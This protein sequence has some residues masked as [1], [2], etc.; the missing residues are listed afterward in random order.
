[1]TTTQPHFDALSLVPFFDRADW[2][3]YRRTGIGASEVASALGESPYTGASALDLWLEKRGEAAP[4][5]VVPDYMKAGHYFEGGILQWWSDVTGRAAVK[6]PPE[7]LRAL[8]LENLDDLVDV[9]VVDRERPWLRA[10]PDAWCLEAEGKDGVGTIEAK[11]HGWF[12]MDKWQDGEATVI[13][14][15]TML[16][17]QTQM[18]VTGCKWAGVAAMIGGQNPVFLDVDYRPEFMERVLPLLDQA[19][20]EIQ[21]GTMP[22]VDAQASTGDALRALYPA[23]RAGSTCMAD[24]ELV[25]RWANLAEQRK[26]IDAELQACKN[27]FAAAMGEAEAALGPQAQRLVTW[28]TGK[29]AVMK[30]VGERENRKG[31]M[32][33]R[34]VR[35]ALGAF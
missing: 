9:I 34:N 17:V 14:T 29:Q 32:L 18:H 8:D 11:N 23:E 15:Y 6:Y 5:E 10:T 2:L 13:P 35:K 28:K 19:W 33:V 21:T 1:M 3:T 31:P 27:E 26:G 4:L 22:A 25:K 24:V 12:V 30:K 20:D 7:L 16:Q